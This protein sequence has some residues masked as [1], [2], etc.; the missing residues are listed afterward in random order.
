MHRTLLEKFQARICYTGTKLAWKFNNITDLVHKSHKHDVVYYATCPEP[1]C[2]EDDTGETG[3]R[4]NERVIDHNG[5]EKNDISVNT[6][7]KVT[8]PELYCVSLKSLVA[9]FKIKC[10]KEKLLHHRWLE[11]SDHHWTRKRCFNN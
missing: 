2:V 6:G 9:I 3:R 7:R 11:S 10:L 5:R 8:I 1:G 4:L